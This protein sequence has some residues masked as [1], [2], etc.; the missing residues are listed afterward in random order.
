[1]RSLSFFDEIDPNVLLI[2]ASKTNLTVLQQD[3]LIIKQDKKSKYI[4]FIMKGRVKIIRQLPI[5]K[6]IADFKDPTPEQMSDPS[7]FELKTLELAELGEYECFGE[8]IANASNQMLSATQLSMQNI[9]YAA[10]SCMPVKCFCIKRRDFYEYIDDRIRKKFMIYLRRYPSNYELRSNYYN[11]R[12]WN[13]F[14]GQFMAEN[15]T[16]PH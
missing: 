14:K 8:D 13:V 2:L 9:P 3:T 16:I 4:Y 6:N 7:A 10:V 5:L 15:T 1:M 12:Y 11:L